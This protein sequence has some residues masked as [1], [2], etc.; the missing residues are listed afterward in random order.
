VAF[1]GPAVYLLKTFVPVGLSPLYEWP[2]QFSPAGASFLLS[3]V[4][5]I[6]L[7]VLAIRFHPYW[8]AGLALWV[9]YLVVLAPMLVP[10]QIGT[11]LA[12]DRCTYV[13][14]VVWA[15][16]A[17]AG[18]AYCW[19]RKGG[20][21]GLG[22][23]VLSV[24]IIVALAG[25]A[26]QYTHVWRDTWSMWER[27]LAVNPRSWH[28]LAGLGGDLKRQADLERDPKKQ[29]EKY[30][31]A[32]AYYRRALEINRDSADLQNNYG[33]ILMTLGRTADALRCYREAVKLNPDMAAAQYNL[34]TAL[35]KMDRDDEAIDPFL[36]AIHLAPQFSDAHYNLANVYARTGKDAEAERHY[37]LALRYDPFNRKAAENLQVIRNRLLRAPK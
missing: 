37:Q 36:K 18:V 32:I 12:A 26:W 1:Y 2:I 16:L 5:V 34:A 22:A 9:V 28:A 35:V 23:S 7:S 10:F 11:H 30:D 33:S 29:Q 4:A 14:C 27:V 17:G 6:A 25:L 8:P 13:A 21:A 19:L 15:L 20:L 24:L 31:E 3:G